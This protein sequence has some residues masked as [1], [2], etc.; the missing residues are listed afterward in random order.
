MA[1]TFKEPEVLRR[2]WRART[3]LLELALMSAMGWKAAV[4]SMVVEALRFS[5]RGFLQVGPAKTTGR[6]H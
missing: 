6:E 1:E 4:A 3:A 2:L 5:T